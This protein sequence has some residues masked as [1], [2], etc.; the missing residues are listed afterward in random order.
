MRRVICSYIPGVGRKIELDIAEAKH[1]TQVLRVENGTEIEV[2]DGKGSKAIARLL[3]SNKKAFIE[4][5][6]PTET[7]PALLS[8]PVH[9]YVAVLKNDA[10]EWVIEKAVE[11]GVRSL[12]PI[13]T[14]YT[15]VQ[16]KKK[17]AD[18][19]LERWQKIADQALKQ[20]GRLD[21]MELKEPIRIQE[22][23]TLSSQPVTESKTPMTVLWLDEGSAGGKGACPHLQTLLLQNLSGPFAI[24]VGPEGGFSPS[25][26]DRLIQLSRLTHSQPR[27]III[28]RVHLGPLVMRAETAVLSAIALIVGTLY[29]NQQNQDSV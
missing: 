26:Q 1:L 6:T 15:V 11:M 16:T 18:V 12:T 22:L 5:I 25:E 28:K 27:A 17:G 14:D 20:C 19:F 9:L 29:G 2:L 13:Q 7:S 10:M 3:I 4:G 21:R 24:L 8:L 23:E